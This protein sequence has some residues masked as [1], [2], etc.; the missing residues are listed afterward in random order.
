MSQ[1]LDAMF[2]PIVDLKPAQI[3]Q[4]ENVRAKAKDLATTLHPTD[5][6][7]KTLALRKLQECVFWANYA[8][9]HS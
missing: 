1:K 7:E 3:Q 4:M 6:P 5:S 2:T 8:I 9:S